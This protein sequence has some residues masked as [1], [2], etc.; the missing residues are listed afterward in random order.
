MLSERNV[1]VIVVVVV[2]VFVVVKQAQIITKM[3]LHFLLKNKSRISPEMLFSIFDTIGYI[4][5]KLT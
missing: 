1:V 2:V 5:I 4:P 3:H